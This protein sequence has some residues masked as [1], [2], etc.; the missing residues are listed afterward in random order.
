MGERLER[1]YAG[2]TENIAATLALHFEQSH[3]FPRALRYLS[4]AAENSAKRFGHEEAINYLSRALGILDRLGTTTDLY[5]PRTSLLRQRSWARRSAGDLAG[6]VRDLEEIIACAADAGQLRHEVNGLLAVSRFCLHADRRMCLHASSEALAKSEALEDDAF[7]A[8]VQGSSAS[9]NL[10]LKGWQEQDAALCEKALHLTADA[11]DH[12]TLIRR[13]GIEGILECLRSRYEECRRSGTDGKKLAQEVGDVYIFV[14]FNVMES[15]ALIHLGQWRRLQRETTAALALAERNANRP[16]I[17]LCRLTLAWLHVE[18]MDFL[19]ARDL[20][21]SVEQAVLEENPFAFFFQRAVV[22]KACVGLNEP[23]RARQQFDDVMQRLNSDG[24]MMDYTIYAQLHHCLCEY[25]LQV[26]D[27]A[28]A[29]RSATKLYEYV[30]PA[31]DRNHLA[32]AHGLLTRVALAAGDF[33]EAR[34]ELSRALSTLKDADLPLAAWRVYR[35]GVEVC[36]TLGE[37]AE[38]ARYRA[39]FED[40]IRTLA[41]NFEPDDRLRSSLLAALDAPGAR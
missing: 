38:A 37:P 13:Y 8:L 39:R 27:I 16:A 2:R 11:R 10:W 36:E 9:I 34:A 31:P 3:D 14:L 33:E 22:A 29:R 17:A 19:G 15:T 30:A 5:G 35:A 1:G 21:E 6:S 41:G 20:C 32:Q 40:V 24:I 23:Q 25:S 18:A 26:G 28:E 12:S 4:Q 7:K